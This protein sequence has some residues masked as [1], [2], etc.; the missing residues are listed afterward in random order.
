MP[1]T[2]FVELLIQVLNMGPEDMDVKELLSSFTANMIAVQAT[3]TAHK[4]RKIARVHSDAE[5]VKMKV[6]ERHS[7]SKVRS[8]APVDHDTKR[9][10]LQPTASSSSSKKPT[11]HPKRH[12]AAQQ[13]PR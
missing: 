11:H 5:E 9:T 4:A 2:P 13:G 1:R 12:Q 3:N 7:Y 8:E 6:A 10:C